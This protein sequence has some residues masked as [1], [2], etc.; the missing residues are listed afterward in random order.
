MLHMA[1]SCFLKLSFKFLHHFA[2]PLVALV[3]P[4]CASIQAIETDSYAETKNL[5]SY[6][7]LL[8]FIYLFEYA[9][10]TLLPWLWVW[11]YVKLMIIFLLTI[12]DFGRATY[13]Y[14]NLIRPMKLQIVVAWRFNE[15]WR[16]CFVEKDDF[17]M[18]A[19]RYVKENGTEAL[20]KLIASKNTMCRPDAEVTNE[21]ISTDN[22]EM[23]KTN[24]ERLQT[25]HLDIKDLEAIEKRETPATKQDIPVIPKVGPSQS[26]S[27]ATTK[28]TAEN[29]RAG[30][31]VPQ[32]STSTQKEM[33][34][35]W[36]C[37]LCLVTTSSEMTLNSHLSGRRHRAR[38]EALIAK[39]QPT[40]QR[41]KDAVTNEILATDD[42][43]M[44]KT[45]GDQ[46][47][48]TEHRDIKEKK[49]IPATKQRTYDNTVA[50]QKASSDIVETKATAESDRA[51]GEI[52]QSSSRLKEVQKEWTCALCLVTT[53]SEATLFS[54]L[55]GKKHMASCEA[56]LKAKKQAALQKLK[57]YQPKEEVK[58]KNV[59]NM[60]NSKVK[61]GDGNVN[62]E[63]E[64]KQKNV[65]NVLNSKVKNGD[66]I[67]NKV[68]KVVLDNKVEKLQKN[69]SE[70]ISIHNSK[71][72]CRV[73]NAVLHCENNVASHLNGKKHLANMQSKVDSL[74][75]LRD[76]GIA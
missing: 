66:G 13:V 17:L 68:L 26:A 22:K 56:A 43:E 33:Q 23:L 27:S 42:K 54:H 19:E 7:I 72:M 64:V 6:W 51:G 10:I 18:H 3:Y 20:E 41:Q 35:E 45:N 63:E 75:N 16:K 71:L 4:M 73:C 70:L 31:E 44:L 9:F 36:T 47:L 76:I 62:K 60:L 32:S 11:L 65:N 15:Y 53:S 74:K 24:G 57:I 55:K 14:N 39:K 30:G 50:S 25:E 21:I 28:G 1:F 67:V 58:Q 37:A 5:I 40:L 29:D 46:R 59:N 48:Q 61:N 12:P 2:W 69:M 38:T 34:K 49:E 52:P 8:S